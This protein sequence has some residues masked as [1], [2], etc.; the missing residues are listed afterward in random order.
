MRAWSTLVM[1]GW[2]WGRSTELERARISADA[3]NRSK[4][5]FMAFLCHE[6]RT[7]LHIVTAN[8][9]FLLD[10][11]LSPVSPPPFAAPCERAAQAQLENAR[12]IDAM[13]KIMTAIVNDVLGI[14]RTQL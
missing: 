11:E 8:G 5:E 6:L 10:T 13:A 2:E 12:T 1:G 14:T 4:G 9:E 7:P 3:A